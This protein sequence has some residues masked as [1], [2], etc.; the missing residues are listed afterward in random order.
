MEK[1]RSTPAGRSLIESALAFKTVT[2]D[3]AGILSKHQNK[4]GQHAREVLSGGAFIDLIAIPSG[5]GQIGSLPSEA[6]RIPNEDDPHT[7][8][9]SAF[10]IAQYPITQAQ[11]RAVAALPK[12]SCTLPS[13][14]SEF[15]G[16]SRPVENV[17]WFEA[18]EFCDR[19]SQATRRCYRLPTESEWEYA[20][21][22]GTISPFTYGQ[23]LTREIANF[24]AS[25]ES[26]SS[27]ETTDVGSY[28]Y[29][30]AFGLEDMHGNVREWCLFDAWGALPDSDYRRPLRGGGW[31][32]TMPAC[33]AA[34]RLMAAAGSQD[35]YTGFRVVHHP[36]EQFI[37][38]HSDARILNSQ[39][40]LNNS[41]NST[42]HVHGN[43]TSIINTLDAE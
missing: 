34:F 4:V 1:P 42:V 11:W 3:T 39:S 33:R 40:L 5:S 7:V 25:A 17:S 9:F 12:V 20:C 6:N 2:I 29:A 15:I 41:P 28:P 8:D 26:S 22:A 23:T 30:N 37:D 14:P 32:D 38:S 21:R 19:L 24:C 35:A 43:Y 31:I 27:S 16:L 36:S 18:V 10:Y 13:A